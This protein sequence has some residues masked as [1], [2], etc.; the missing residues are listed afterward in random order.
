MRILGPN[1][2]GFI[3]INYNGSFAADT[4]KKG[5]IAMI[6]QSGAM[7]TGMMDYSMEQTYGFSCNI[8]LG[9]NADLGAIDFI[10][11]L[12]DDDN[13]EVILCYLE[14]IDNGAKFLEIAGKAARKKPIVRTGLIA[15]LTPC[16]KLACH[17]S[18]QKLHPYLAKLGQVW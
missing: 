5:K 14:S 9:N 15:T 10:E 3:G 12:V 4:P 13:T 6:S 11:Y 16:S 17:Y 1:C 18:I 7:L 8:S 2:L